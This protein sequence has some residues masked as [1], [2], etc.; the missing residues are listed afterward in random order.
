VTDARRA[1]GLGLAAGL[2]L[3]VAAGTALGLRLGRPAPVAPP[4]AAG[5]VPGR[6]EPAEHPATLQEL[7]AEAEWWRLAYEDLARSLDGALPG[8]Q[9]A[10]GAVQ[11]EGAAGGAASAAAEQAA[12]AA[13][14]QAADAATAA[15]AG[16]GFDAAALLARGY[17]EQEVERLRER[18]EAYE[19][20][21]L[22][23]GDRA[24]REGWQGRGR[25]KIAAKMLQDALRAELGD[26]DYDAALYASGRNNRVRVAGV[27]A[28]SAAERAGLRDGD[29]LISY[30]GRRIFD[31]QSVVRATGEGEPGSTTELRVR[32]GDEELR[33]DLPRGPIGIRL[34][35]VRRTPEGFP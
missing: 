19:L 30:D 20:E 8:A 25:H 21:L 35:A 11:E 12:N 5:S 2:A 29:E 10:A 6:G 33:V 27:L 3:G 1:A 13:A 18:F 24:H 23:L 15:V 34:E 17:T 7:E 16:A 9:V 22:Y 14:V 31:V 28:G 32:R 4:T 26:R